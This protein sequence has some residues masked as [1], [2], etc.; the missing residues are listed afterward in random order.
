MFEMSID[1]GEVGISDELV[2]LCTLLWLRRKWYFEALDF[3]NVVMMIAKVL[4]DRRE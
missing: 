4:R 3:V 2:N 1:P